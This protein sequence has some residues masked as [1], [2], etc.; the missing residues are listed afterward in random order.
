MASRAAWRQQ[1]GG[2]LINLGCRLRLSHMSLRFPVDTIAN[3]SSI[4]TSFTNS[5]KDP[6]SYSNPQD[7]R[8]R[9]ANLIVNVSF[10]DRKLRGTAN[11]FL[12]RLNR[13][14]SHIVLDTM[15]LTILNVQDSLGQEYHPLQ[16]ELGDNDPILGAPLTVDLPDGVDCIS[17]EYL[18]QPDARGLQW[19]EPRLTAGGKD[20]FLLTQSQ[21]INARSWLPLQDSP[22][23]RMTFS[24][25]IQCP[26]HLMAVMGAA[27]NPQALGKGKYYFEMPQ[28][29]PSYLMA[30]AVGNLSFRSLSAR[31]GVYAEK[32]LVEAA[33]AEF[34]DLELMMQ[35]AENL[36]GPYRW[37]RYDVLVLPPSFPVGGM[38][39]PRLTFA[40]PTILAGDKS[41]VSVLAHEVGHSWAGNLVTNATWND[42]WLNE[43]FSVYVERRLIEEIYGRPRAEMEAS[44][45]WQELVEEIARLGDKNELL[46]GSCNHGDPEDCITK[47]PYEKGA[48]FLLQLEKVFGRARFDQFLREYFDHF[49]FQSIT[50]ADFVD[51]L[52][53]NLFRQHPALAELI[54]INEWLYEPGIPA[55]ASLPSS[56]IFEVI[57]SEARAWLKRRKSAA[58]LRVSSWTVQEWLRF[59]NY[60]PHDLSANKLAELDEQFQFTSSKNSEIVHQ[61]ML[62]TIRADYRPAVE[63][64]EEFLIS[65]GRERL[66]KP[67]YEELV[68]SEKGK[69]WARGVYQKARCGYNPIVVKKLDQVLEWQK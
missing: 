22:Q 23:V 55:S 21:A 58:E 28:P 59:L 33:A 11:L 24:A 12:E 40:T 34:S 39:N 36:Y 13:N 53:Q 14:V 63:R 27:N 7:V 42:L 38:E 45:G 17:I 50:T 67:L 66:I 8:V 4:E 2:F 15:D 47:I 35:R 32:A 61:W 65:V 64:L 69:I 16:F 5:A 29:V 37:D 9:H 54:P 43:G 57:E 3:P 20:P 60:L 49:A 41:L 46:Y 19:L 48:L 6:H 26:E 68:K 56:Q 52:K 25:Y 31:T 10:E 51:Y 62:M 1:K 18:T 30:L 44:L